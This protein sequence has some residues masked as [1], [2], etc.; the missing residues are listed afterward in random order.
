M[1]T[2]SIR[3]N[4]KRVFRLFLGS[5]IVV[6]TMLGLADS[7]QA[8]PYV[9]PTNNQLT[10]PGFEGPPN[11]RPSG[12]GGL[13]INANTDNALGWF[14]AGTSQL[15]VVQV[16]GPGPYDYYS[17]GPGNDATGLATA[18][19]PRRYLDTLGP[20]GVY[21][22]FTTPANCS[23]TVNFG[24]YFSTRANLSGSGSLSIVPGTDPSGV[25]LA[26]SLPVSLPSNTTTIPDPW[27]L[28]SGSIGLTANTS[29]V[30]KVSMDNNLNMDE[31]YVSFV[32]G[33]CSDGGGSVLGT[34]TV[35]PNPAIVGQPLTFTPNSGCLSA[36]NAQNVALVYTVT[37]VG[38]SGVT[39][40]PISGP[41]FT[42][43]P[44]TVSPGTFSP[45]SYSVTVSSPPGVSPSVS[46]DGCNGAFVVA[47]DGTVPIVDP[48]VGAGVLLL[49]VGGLALRRR[50]QLLISRA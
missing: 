19:V 2:F 45:G 40:I 49:G 4:A 38:G 16:D 34:V 1:R 3:M 30:F 46:V 43:S 8:T 44:P 18:A 35:T 5:S 13:L 23:G 20:G 50:R 47:A 9:A 32:T 39:H 14:D 37:Q 42:L 10:N 7:A 22:V 31:A 21:Q 12:N 29:Y 41:P 24:A 33:P 28:S 25:G 17:Y 48:R 15:N 11:P 6:G 26:A 36:M 27:V